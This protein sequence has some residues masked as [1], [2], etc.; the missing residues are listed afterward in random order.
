M[1]ICPP[2]K[3]GT[4]NSML[5]GQVCLYKGCLYRGSTV[6]PYGGY[7]C[8]R[9]YEATAFTSVQEVYSRPFE[10]LDRE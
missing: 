1:L 3:N 9:P 8:R 4:G 7:G 6:Y 5:I 2:K 10:A